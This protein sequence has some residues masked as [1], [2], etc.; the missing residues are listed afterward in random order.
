MIKANLFYKTRSMTGLTVT[1]KKTMMKASVIRAGV[2]AS[3]IYLFAF[4]IFPGPAASAAPPD[5]YS[6]SLQNQTG[7]DEAEYTIYALGYSTT[8]KMMLLND[9]TFGPFP[10]NNGTIPSYPVGPGRL[11]QITIQESVQLLGARVYF[12]VAGATA[13]APSFPYSGNGAQ[14]TQPQNPPNPNYP[15]YSFVEITQN[16]SFSATPVIDV[17]T[18]DGFIFPLTITL[19]NS[20][21]QVGQPL[22]AGPVDR[23]SIFNAYTPFMSQLGTAGQPYEELLFTEAGGGLLNPFVYLTEV[24][25]QGGYIYLSSPL[26]TAFDEALDTMFSDINLRPAGR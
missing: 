17:Q 2:C 21:G 9:G 22:P 12:F 13:A 11:S 26:N 8:S 16:P 23:T 5:S 24:N 6:I 4:G 18:V 19:N 1:W 20:L 14:V 7:L 10:A 15:P 25:P 3:V